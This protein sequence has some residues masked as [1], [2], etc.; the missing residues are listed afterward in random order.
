MGL[1]TRLGEGRGPLTRG[2]NHG[3][4]QGPSS[5][6]GKKPWAFVISMFPL[7]G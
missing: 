2:V 7:R 4:P 5:S 1:V 3:L 6:L